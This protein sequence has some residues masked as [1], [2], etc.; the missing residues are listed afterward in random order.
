M[1]VLRFC[2]HAYRA[3]IAIALVAAVSIVSAP[4]PQIDLS[5]PGAIALAA[6]NGQLEGFLKFEN[7]VSGLVVKGESIRKGF[8]DEIEVDSASFAVEAN[9]ETGCGSG[10]SSGR[11]EVQ[12]LKINKRLDAAS[13]KLAQMI[14]R[15]LRAETA[16]VVFQK[17]PTVGAI[18]RKVLEYELKNAGVASLD[19][20]IADNPTESLSLGFT[21]VTIRYFPSDAKGRILTPVLTCFDFAE[22]IPC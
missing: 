14:F 2:T 21:Q 8:E 18:A 4:A 19:Q 10:C 13:P 15:G 7:I 6:Y 11:P 1:A 20:S 12:P 17:P 9:L 5:T 16:R 3:A 22:N